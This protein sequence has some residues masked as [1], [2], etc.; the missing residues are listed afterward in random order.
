[1]L[2]GVENSQGK[3]EE[4]IR[5][6]D[7]ELRGVLEERALVEGMRGEWVERVEGVIANVRR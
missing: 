6:L 4:R 5:E 7:V 2:P 1:M 3:Q